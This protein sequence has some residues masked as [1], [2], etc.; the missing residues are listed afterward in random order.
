MSTG[1]RRNCEDGRA[2]VDHSR[3]G[4][5]MNLLEPDEIEY[6]REVRVARPGGV[7]DDAGNYTETEATIIECMTADIQL[8]L[9]IRNLVSENETGVSD[10]TLWIMYCVP[11]A[12]IETGDRVYDGTRIFRVEAVGDWGSHTECVI[13][14]V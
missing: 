9:K 5:D 8:S 6:S 7:Y 14:E 11:P 10:N 1:V 3:E 2:P 4:Y 12:A 13:V